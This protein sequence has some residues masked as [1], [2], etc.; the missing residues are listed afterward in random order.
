[1]QVF[2]SLN[3]QKRLCYISRLGRCLGSNV[4]T[5]MDC[6]QCI[7]SPALQTHP[8]NVLSSWLIKAERIQAAGAKGPEASHC[9]VASCFQMDMEWKE[10]G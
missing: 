10:T 3:D 7:S 4:F 8:I 1:M 9:P 5:L 6:P 2:L